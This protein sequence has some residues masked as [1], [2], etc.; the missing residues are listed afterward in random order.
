MVKMDNNIVYY[1]N[2]NTHETQWEHPGAEG[3]NIT[4]KKSIQQ[5]QNILI[6][7]PAQ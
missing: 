7:V 5:L 2:K 4:E 3:N 6:S 1:F